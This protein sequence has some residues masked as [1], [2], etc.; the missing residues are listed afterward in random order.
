MLKTN[1][2]IYILAEGNTQNASIIVRSGFCKVKRNLYMKYC[3]FYVNSATKLL[4]P[5]I[6]IWRR[7][8]PYRNGVLPC[9]DDGIGLQLRGHECRPDK[10]LY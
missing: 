5:A 8:D 3:Y 1:H 7:L 2:C 6:N 10:L 4:S 9:R